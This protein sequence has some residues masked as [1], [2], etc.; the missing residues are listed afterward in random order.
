MLI[1]RHR[2]QVPAVLLFLPAI[3][4]RLMGVA[5]H[6]GAVS[7]WL[8]QRGCREASLSIGSV[9]LPT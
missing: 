9:D 7:Q 6:L 4:F 5:R 1:P 2:R 3:L 8:I